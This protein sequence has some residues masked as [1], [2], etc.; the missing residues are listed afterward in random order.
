MVQPS[1]SC[2]PS[3]CYYIFLLSTLFPYYHFNTQYLLPSQLS[4]SLQKFLLFLSTCLIVESITMELSSNSESSSA[5]KPYYHLGF[6]GCMGFYRCSRNQEWHG[7]L[8][9]LNKCRSIGQTKHIGNCPK[10]VSPLDSELF[11]IF[12]IPLPPN[13]P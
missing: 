9:W 3:L 13:L 7:L 5:Q 1:F 4:L 8:H 10:R 12:S 2:Q 11:M 6:R